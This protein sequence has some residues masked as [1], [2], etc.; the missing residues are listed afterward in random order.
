MNK[1]QLINMLG[2]RLVDDLPPEVFSGTTREQRRLIGKGARPLIGEIV[3]SHNDY[4]E[5]ICAVVYQPEGLFSLAEV[6]AYLGLFLFGNVLQRAGL[7]D[8]IS[9]C[10][11]VQ[12]D[13]SKGFV[14][15]IEN[16]L[17]NSLKQLPLG[18][19]TGLGEDAGA[20]FKQAAGSV[21]LVSRLVGPL[22]SRETRE[23]EAFRECGR[24]LLGVMALARSADD[25]ADVDPIR[26][27]K[28]DGD[29]V[30]CVTTSGS[31]SFTCSWSTLGDVLRA[32]VDAKFIT[33]VSYY[34]DEHVLVGYR[35][36]YDL[37]APHVLLHLL[38]DVKPSP[39]SIEVAP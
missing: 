27:R 29:T 35:P 2:K 16:V 28:E 9:D 5:I 33:C 7:C 22:P 12:L 18:F 26:L 20:R 1:E 39:D 24:G 21:A 4:G 30:S 8:L 37:A 34:P 15:H 3:E 10:G 31:T 19:L 25:P 38:V 11:A 23:W 32:A 6:D 13:F 36:L 17:R 14:T